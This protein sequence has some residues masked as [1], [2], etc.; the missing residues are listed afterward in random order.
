LTTGIAI[1]VALLVAG[2]LISPLIWILYQSS[3][4]FHAVTSLPPAEVLNE[5]VD[6]FA[7]ND[8]T[9]QHKARDFVLLKK[10]PSGVTGCLLLVLCLPV[11]LAYLLTDW[12]TGKTAVRVWENDERAT[13]VEIAWRNAT[14]RGQVAKALR[15]LEEQDEG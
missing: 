11:G 1:L 6:F 12:G 9:V 10:S 3:G 4:S 14:I 7:L 2:L 5:V 13:D 8:W 15:W